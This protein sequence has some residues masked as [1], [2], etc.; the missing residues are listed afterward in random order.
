MVGR[1]RVRLAGTASRSAGLEMDPNPIESFG[2]GGACE[3]DISDDAPGADKVGRDNVPR[4][5]HQIGGAL[6]VIQG[7]RNGGKDQR[8]RRPDDLGS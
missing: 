7:I 3:V 5:G 6:E 1:E 8:E 2:N 4:A